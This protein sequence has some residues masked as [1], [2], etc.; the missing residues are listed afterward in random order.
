M[1]HDDLQAARTSDQNHREQA[2]EKQYRYEFDSRQELLYIE[3]LESL[4]KEYLGHADHAADDID[5]IQQHLT[6][7]ILSTRKA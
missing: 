3:Q 7:L 5:F 2:V 4:L 6:E 1:M